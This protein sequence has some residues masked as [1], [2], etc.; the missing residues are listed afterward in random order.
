M[1]ERSTCTVAVTLMNCGGAAPDRIVTVP[2]YCPGSV[3][4]AGSTVIVTGDG[5]P[6]AVRPIGDEIW[7]HEASLR[8]LYGVC[9]ADCVVRR[10]FWPA[11]AVRFA[12]V[13]LR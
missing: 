8:S 12:T 13:K 5:E 3:S 7:I 1:L 10:M 2:L 6:E 11:D 4:C 9:P